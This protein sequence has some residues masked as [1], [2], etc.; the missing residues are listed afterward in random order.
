M[1]WTHLKIWFQQ[2]TGKLFST[3]EYAPTWMTNNF[4]YTVNEDR[5]I[6][7]SLFY[8]IRHLMLADH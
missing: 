5:F 8:S 1:I 6:W 4:N 2:N 7:A 3:E